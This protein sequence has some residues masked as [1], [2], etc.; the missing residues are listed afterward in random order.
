MGEVAKVMTGSLRLNTSCSFTRTSP[1]ISLHQTCTMTSEPA[2]GQNIPYPQVF[3]V[4][5]G[6]GHPNQPLPNLVPCWSFPQAHERVRNP[7]RSG[8]CMG[9]SSRLVVL[10]LLLFALVFASLG[11]GAVWTVNLQRD[12]KD[13]QKMVK[14]LNRST[15]EIIVN[16]PQKQIGLYEPPLKEETKVE[17]ERPAA[18]VLGYLK[19]NPTHKTL[20]WDLHKS[21]AFTSGGVAYKTKDGALQVNHTGLYYIYSRVE[22]IFK[23][24]NSTSFFDHTVFVRRAGHSSPLTLMEAHRR[25]FCPSEPGRPWT[26]DSFLGAALQLQKY[27]RV[28]VSVSHPDYLSH[29][30]YAN[31]FGLYKI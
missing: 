15:E 30:H 16:A 8:G 1:F 18:H 7:G 23:T 13:M 28:L 12:L 22:L 3:I 24:C 9:A 11:L 14:V 2:Y 20:K 4:D 25:G 19:N 6:G 27:D 17:E 5:G 31:F 26:T 10:V 29:E 21:R